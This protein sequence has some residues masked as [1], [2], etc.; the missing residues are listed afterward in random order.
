MCMNCGCGEPEERHDSPS[1]ITRSDL[2]RAGEANGQ[3][4]AETMRNLQ[5]AY[6][7]DRVRAGQQ[8]LLPVGHGSLSEPPDRG[9][10]AA[11]DPWSRVAAR[12][13]GREGAGWLAVIPWTSH[14]R[15]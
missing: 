11:R 7:S 1:N 2:E 6:R 8:R 3:T 5:E 14:H 12:L 4:L 13:I 10:A 15:S 9:R